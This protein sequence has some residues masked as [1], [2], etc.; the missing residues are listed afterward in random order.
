MVG[1][2]HPYRAVHMR[3]MHS[4]ALGRIHA[5]HNLFPPSENIQKKTYGGITAADAVL[6]CN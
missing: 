2:D 4:M 3:M 1:R 6:Y 5:V